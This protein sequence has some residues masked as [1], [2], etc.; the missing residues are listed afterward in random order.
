[1]LKDPPLDQRLTQD[2]KILRSFEIPELKELL[3]KQSLFNVGISQIGPEDYRDGFEFA[4]SVESKTFWKRKAE[5]VSGKF[6]RAWV[7]LLPAP[8]VFKL[9]DLEPS[10]TNDFKIVW[11]PHS[12]NSLVLEESQRSPIKC[13]FSKAVLSLPAPNV[14]D[15]FP[16]EESI[17]VAK[18]FGIAPAKVQLTEVAR[19]SRTAPARV[20]LKASTLE[21]YNLAFEL[22][23]EATRHR[24]EAKMLK[25]TK[26]KVSKVIEEA[27][28]RTDA[29]E[30]RA[31]EVEATLKKSVEENS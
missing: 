12:S 18:T 31:Q 4:K 1:M 14:S 26:D 10:T 11:I 17:E 20:Q 16:E 13:L 7:G 15:L 3:S 21:D 5:M 30:K 27:F 23:T 22:L 24:M 8:S 25:I 29:T 9:E 19:T 2:L 6:A 28:T